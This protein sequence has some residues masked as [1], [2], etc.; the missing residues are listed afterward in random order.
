MMEDRLARLETMIREI[1]D[2]LYAGDDGSRARDEEAFRR[3]VR[4]LGKGNRRPLQLYIQRGGKIPKA[5][6]R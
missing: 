1:H 2:F 6:E 3:A 5:G 4:E